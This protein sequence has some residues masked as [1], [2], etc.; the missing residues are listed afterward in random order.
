[1]WVLIMEKAYAVFRGGEGTYAN[2][3]S[4]YADDVFDAM[5]VSN[6]TFSALQGPMTQFEFGLR[7]KNLLAAG[8][9]VTGATSGGAILED[10]HVYTID[11]VNIINGNVASV[12]VRNPWG[13]DGHGGDST[14]D[15]YVTL[16]LGQAMLAFGSFTYGMG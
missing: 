2:L 5:G 15:G 8:E 9:T 16:S 1:M 3:E 7:L 14:D 13:T 6:G 11:H 4:G 12:V 10:S